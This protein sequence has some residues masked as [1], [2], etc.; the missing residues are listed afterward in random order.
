MDTHF[1]SPVYSGLIPFT[2]CS[3]IGLLLVLKEGRWGR[4]G[5]RW[6]PSGAP[7]HHLCPFFPW[8]MCVSPNHAMFQP[9]FPVNSSVCL[10]NIRSLVL[11]VGGDT[12]AADLSVW[13]LSSLSVPPL[14]ALTTI[15]PQLIRMRSVLLMSPHIPIFCFFSPHLRTTFR[16]R[17][18][19]PVRRT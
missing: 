14:D 8:S 5:G 10:A 17:A 6:L 11:N 1:P 19:S 13:F 4:W 2:S 16:T 12:S 7:V 3:L 18:R 15:A 9:Q